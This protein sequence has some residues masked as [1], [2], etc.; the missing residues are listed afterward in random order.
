MNCMCTYCMHEGT[1]TNHSTLVPGHCSLSHLQVTSPGLGGCSNTHQGWIGRE[2]ALTCLCQ[3]ANLVGLQG[4]HGMFKVLA[5]ALSKVRH[6][7]WPERFRAKR[8]RTWSFGVFPFTTWGATWLSQIEPH[9]HQYQAPAKILPFQEVDQDQPHL[10]ANRGPT[11][12]CLQLRSWLKMVKH[13]QL[14]SSNY[15]LI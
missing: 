11:Y 4:W 12:R 13:F 5:I 15:Y 1:W 8:N 10:G 3:E 7:A 6:S 9:A 14:I 2:L